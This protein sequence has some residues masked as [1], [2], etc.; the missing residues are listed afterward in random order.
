MRLLL[1]ENLDWRL[2]RDLPGHS[3]TSVSRAGWSGVKNGE[4]LKRANGDFDVLLTMD[5]GIYHQQN[6]KGLLLAIVTL[7]SKSNRLAD[8]RPLMP[9]LLSLLPNI[10][11]GEYHTLPTS[12]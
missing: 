4:L 7:R 3:V 2:E 11:P 12:S 6:L 5:Q 10:K 8:T 1:D 9:A